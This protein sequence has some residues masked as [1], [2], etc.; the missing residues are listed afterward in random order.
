MENG[1]LDLL[2]DFERVIC[3]HRSTLFCC[4]DLLFSLSFSVVV[5][6]DLHTIS[7]SASFGS[8]PPHFRPLSNL[9]RVESPAASEEERD[10][11][12]RR[13][14]SLLLFCGSVRSVFGW[15]ARL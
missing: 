9:P 4:L 11:T 5:V 2:K 10:Q 13:P 15:H 12:E 14:V 3:V 1:C 8:L 6:R 7:R